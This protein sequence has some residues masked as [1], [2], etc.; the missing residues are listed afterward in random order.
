M[1]SVDDLRKSNFLTKKDVEPPVLVTISGYDEYNV[2]KEG[3]E[4]EIRWALHFKE[5][6]KPLILN[7]TNGSIIKH[8][9]GS[10]NFDDW[11]GKKIV[12][13]NDETI[14]FGGKMT[15]GIRVR[16]P[17]KGY[18]EPEQKMKEDDSIPF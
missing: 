7:V 6:E 11:I 13:Y 10:G 15:G 2:A 5:L 3:A 9:T 18:Q 17:K 8:I 1:P 14:M 12:L 4:Q 16:A